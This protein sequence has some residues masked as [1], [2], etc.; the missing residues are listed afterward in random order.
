MVETRKR[1]AEWNSLG[2]QLC[3]AFVDV[4]ERVATPA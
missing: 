2:R 4:A 3:D 1:I